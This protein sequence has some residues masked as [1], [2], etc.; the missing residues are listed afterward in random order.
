M[1][2]VWFHIL[3][4]C[5][6]K[7]NPGQFWKDRGDSPLLSSFLP[8]LS[9]PILPRIPLVLPSTPKLILITTAEEPQ[10]WLTD[11][12]RK[13]MS[14][15]G[16]YKWT[17]VCVCSQGACSVDAYLL[18]SVCMH[19][20]FVCAPC[21]YV[22]VFWSVCMHAFRCVSV[23]LYVCVFMC[24]IACWLAAGSLQIRLGLPE[25]HLWRGDTTAQ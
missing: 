9:P 19:A 14:S 25:A 16:V 2:Y 24:G 5:S 3:F 22:C 7:E 11:V 6:W 12:R 4:V 20:V 18:W 17:L 10:G 13:C 21:V 15:R 23:H 1:A 8:S